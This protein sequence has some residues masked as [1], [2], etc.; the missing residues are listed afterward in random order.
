M[1]DERFRAHVHINAV[2]S[3]FPGKTE[4]PLQL[5]QRSLVCPDFREQAIHEGECQQLEEHEIGPDLVDLVQGHA[6]YTQFR[7]TATVFDSTGW[8][9]EDYV[10]VKLLT[11]LAEEAG[12]GEY[13]ELESVSDDPKSPYGFLDLAT[14][15]SVSSIAKSRLAR[16]R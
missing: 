14:E 16:M 15:R 10:S 5:L 2:G 9:L 6:R 12:L 3:D 13:V 11:R 1:Q 8:A 4:L 7:D